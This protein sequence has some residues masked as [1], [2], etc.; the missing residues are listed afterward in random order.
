MKGKTTS[1]ERKFCSRVFA[2]PSGCWE[3]TG[4]LQKS[5][6]Y[7]VLDTGNKRNGTRKVLRAH[8][9]S[10][11][12]YKGQ[13]PEGLFVCHKC[14][15]RKCVNPDHLFLGTNQDNVNDMIS[16]GRNTRGELVKGSVFKEQDVIKIREMYLSGLTQADIWRAF[17]KKVTRG[18]IAKIVRY[19]RWKHVV[20]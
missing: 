3:W 5:S 6:G 8:R 9:I 15:N 20:I 16:K 12:L 7:G 2:C 19:E 18:T 1:I 11:N 10:W 13:I 4:E 14:D 17:D